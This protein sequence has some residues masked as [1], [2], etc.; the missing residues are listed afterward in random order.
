[1][2]PSTKQW[3]IP[4]GLQIIPGGLLLVGSFF[5]TESPRWLRL[6]GQ[7]ERSIKTLAWIRKLDED[8]K[9]ILE[10]IEMIDRQLAT[11]RDYTLRRQFSEIF[12]KGIRNRLVAGLLMMM[13]Q[14]LT[15]VNAINYYSTVCL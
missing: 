15:G 7:E 6:H 10:E 14:N 3:H 2:S 5:L 1:M 9:Y 12:R 13:F 4:I 8:D 11:V